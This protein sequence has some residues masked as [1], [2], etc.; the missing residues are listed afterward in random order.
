MDEYNMDMLP[1]FLAVISDKS[2][3]WTD[4]QIYYENVEK[5]YFY[6]LENS[7]KN[8]YEKAEVSIIKGFA[9]GK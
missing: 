3:T 9:E 8:D 7:I 1:N 4:I 2:P 5:Y 6:L